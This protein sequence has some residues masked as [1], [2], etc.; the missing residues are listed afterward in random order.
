MNLQEKLDQATELVIHSKFKEALSLL[1]EVSKSVAPKLVN[2]VNMQKMELASILSTEQKMGSNEKTDLRRKE[3]GLQLFSFIDQ[4]REGPQ[5]VA[6]GSTPEAVY[7][8]GALRNQVAK[9]KIKQALK[10]M[11]EITK[12]MEDLHLQ[13]IN[14]QGQ[15]TDVGKGELL[16]TL[17]FSDISVRKAQITN[18]LLQ[19]INELP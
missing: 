10:E 18:A 5:E 2:T 17:S 3:L 16:G 14:L 9:N 7:D 11:N 6:E 19:L 4:L 8:K 15:W 1:G 13:I 12:N